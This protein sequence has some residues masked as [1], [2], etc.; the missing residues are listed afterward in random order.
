MRGSS[1]FPLI[2]SSPLEMKDLSKKAD[3]VKNIF[4]HLNYRKVG[5]ISSLELIALIL[6][7]IN[8]S[9]ESM[10]KNVIMIFGFTDTETQQRI[11]QDEFNF[12]IDC[13]FKGI[14]ALVQTPQ[15]AVT[16]V[17]LHNYKKL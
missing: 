10:M 6:L 16:P 12:F 15:S 8:G 4:N 11:T 1:P 5:R 9:L 14:L 13:L 7:S 2:Y 3:S 17:D